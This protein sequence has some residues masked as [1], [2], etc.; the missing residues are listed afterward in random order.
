[1][2]EPGYDERYVRFFEC[3]N[4]QLFFEAHEALESLWLPQ[5]QGP[6][7]RFYKG[8]IQIAGA[9][10]H[11]Q[12]ARPGP[13]IRLLELARENLQNYPPT[14]EGLAVGSVLRL[15]EDWLRK[16]R[17]ASSTHNAFTAATAPQLRLGHRRD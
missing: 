10:L 2:Q 3:F 6:Q 7:G 12:K 14:H 17:S 11:L 15:I 5:R 9:F 4:Q 8:L 13:A 16:S 1:M